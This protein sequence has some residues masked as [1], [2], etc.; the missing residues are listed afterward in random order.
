MERVLEL[1]NKILYFQTLLINVIII[2]LL[3]AAIAHVPEFEHESEILAGAAELKNPTK[4]RVLYGELREHDGVHYYSMKLDAGQRLK[5]DLFSPDKEFI[6]GLVVMGPGISS[7][8]TLPPFVETANGSGALVI[9]GIMPPS[10]DYEPFTPGSYYHTADFDEEVNA[11]GMYFAAVY[12]TDGKG[13]YGLAAG[14]VESFSLTEWVSVPVDTLKIHAWEGQKTAVV[15]SPMLITVIIGFAGILL[16]RNGEFA[17][18]L[19]EPWRALAFTG[20][21][22]YTGSGALLLAQ[23]ARSLG[24]SGATDAAAVTLIFAA[25][26]VIPGLYILRKSIVKSGILDRKNRFYIVIIGFLGFFIWAGHLVGP[27]LIIA[28]AAVPLKKANNYI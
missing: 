6:P 13:R 27:V 21:L 11:S 17:G 18:T 15:L 4:S 20:G 24:I 8:G 23:M 9:E 3:P 5:L 25:V 7:A 12:P 28:S 22:L 16:F 1:L 2:F 14:Y 26:A 10:A 19:R